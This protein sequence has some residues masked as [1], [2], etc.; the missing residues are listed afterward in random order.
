MTVRSLMSRRRAICLFASPSRTRPR[1]SASRLVSCTCPEPART[2]GGRRA[3]EPE[4]RRRLEFI[5]RGRA[6]GFGIE[7]IRALLRLSDSSPEPCGAV[8]GI[9]EAHLQ[10]VRAKIADLQRLEAVLAATV[11]A[12]HAN[13][14]EAACPVLDML[15]GHADASGAGPGKGGCCG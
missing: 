9:A 10:D 14:D 6:L 11:S 3:Y 8:I 12:C 7:N 4:H 1:T 15:E 2:P 13:G 5:R